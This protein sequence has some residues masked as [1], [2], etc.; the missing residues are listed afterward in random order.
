M[1]EYFEPANNENHVADAFAKEC[2]QGGDENFETENRERCGHAEHHEEHE[3]HRKHKDDFR[4]VV[5][6]FGSP[7]LALFPKSFECFLAACR[8]ERGGRDAV[9][10]GPRTVGGE[11]L[12]QEVIVSAL[13]FDDSSKAVHALEKALAVGEVVA[14][15]REGEV[16]GKSSGARDAV[17]E[18]LDGLHA[19]DE[20]RFAGFSRDVGVPGD[21]FNPRFEFLD[22]TLDPGRLHDAVG[23]REAE[24]FAIADFDH[25]AYGLLFGAYTFGEGINGEHMQSVLELGFVFGENLRGVV[26]GAVVSHP[27]FPF[28]FVIL[29]EDGV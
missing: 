25:L 10:H 22:D 27:D 3:H 12:H 9:A 23:I 29:G 20:W 16:H 17:N 28:A 6:C 13:D 15:A 4:G 7:A 1:L 2:N 21:K 18:R 19:D 5:D 8:D 24:N 26:R 11:F 14:R